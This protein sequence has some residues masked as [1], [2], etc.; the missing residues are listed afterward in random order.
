[1]SW[2]VSLL[3]N[4]YPRSFTE[5]KIL[6]AGWWGKEIINRIKERVVS[7]QVIFFEGREETGVLFFRL[8]FYC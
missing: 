8:P 6:E 7:R 4:R 1:M 5:W 3:I 2:A